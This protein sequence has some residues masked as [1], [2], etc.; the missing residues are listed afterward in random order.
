MS[1]TLQPTLVRPDAGIPATLG[2]LDPSLLELDADWYD[3]KP[4]ALE[5]LWELRRP[6]PWAGG[7]W[8]VAAVAEFDSEGRMGCYYVVEPITHLMGA[9][10]PAMLPTD[11]LADYQQLLERLDPFVGDSLHVTLNLAI[12]DG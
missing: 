3:R 9:T 10:K 6:K 4:W 11:T 5:A 1:L 12:S 2:L 8:T 7:V